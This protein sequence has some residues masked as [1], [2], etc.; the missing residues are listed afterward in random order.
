M[1]YFINLFLLK[2]N[3]ESDS[4][5]SILNESHSCFCE[6]DYTQYVKSSPGLSGLKSK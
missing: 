3:D 1:I 2:K 6:C 4:H 5:E